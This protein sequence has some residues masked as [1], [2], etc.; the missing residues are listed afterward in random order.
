MGDSPALISARAIYIAARNRKV[1]AEIRVNRAI[2][3][4]C[5]C[6][7]YL[8]TSSPEAIRANVLVDQLQA[9][10]RNLR[11]AADVA[12][13]VL[14]AALAADAKNSRRDE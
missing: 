12:G 3:N 1:E 6:E 2:L 7:Y 8:G 5:H 11:G 13:K 10:F 9:E 4:A 14:W